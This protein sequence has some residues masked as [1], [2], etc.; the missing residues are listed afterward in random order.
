MQIK[1]TWIPDD[2]S[3]EEAMMMVAEYDIFQLA[4]KYKIPGFEPEDIAQELRIHLWNRLPKYKPKMASPRTWILCI[5][6][7]KVYDLFR[8]SLRQKREV[9]HHTC[10]LDEKYN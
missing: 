6:R 4:L 5:L 8:G 2:L 1:I 3:F 10:Q 9:H 7:R